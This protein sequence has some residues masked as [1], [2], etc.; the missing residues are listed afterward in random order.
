MGDNGEGDTGAM[1]A[2][3]SDYIGITA[4]L[5]RRGGVRGMVLRPILRV[6]RAM[7]V[8]ELRGPRLT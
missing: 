2:I 5:F 6:S 8:P 4:Y 1:R 3:I 7:P